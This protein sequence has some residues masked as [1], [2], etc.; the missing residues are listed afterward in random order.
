[1]GVEVPQANGAHEPAA[2]ASAVEA[3]IRYLVPQSD[4]LVEYTY[5]PDNGDPQ[6]NGNL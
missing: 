3:R 6:T 4:Q 5:K 1:M 2:F